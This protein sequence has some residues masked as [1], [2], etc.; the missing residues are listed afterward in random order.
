MTVDY[1]RR[2]RAYSIG[3]PRARNFLR[4]DV[5]NQITAVAEV[6]MWQ[7]VRLNLYYAN[8]DAGSTL[9]SRAFRTQLLTVGISL[10]SA[11]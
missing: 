1:R 10:R 5:R 8:Q 7:H 2:I 4:E 3:D 11:S 6:G 9:S